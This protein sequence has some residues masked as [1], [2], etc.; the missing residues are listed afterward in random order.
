MGWLWG[1]GGV[2]KR[3]A[4]V[5]PWATLILPQSARLA[6]R[7]PWVGQGAAKRLAL[8][9]PWVTLALTLISAPAP[10]PMVTAPRLLLHHACLHQGRGVGGVAGSG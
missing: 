5:W 8:L 2:A 1:G 10:W 3:L 4:L 7:W 9:W 6:M